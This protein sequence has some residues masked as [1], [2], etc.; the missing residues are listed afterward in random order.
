MRVTPQREAIFRLLE[1]NDTHPT[2]EA[3]YE[4]ARA[5]LPTI[6]LKTVYHTVHDLEALG[7]VRLLDLGTGS[8]R[9]DPNA[10]PHAHLVCVRCGSVQGVSFDASE[11]EVPGRLRRGFDVATVEVIFRGVCEG[12]TRTR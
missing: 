5:N 3:L 8:T 11:L 9:V 12:C 1:G 2:V 4:M 6:S 10:E 7:E